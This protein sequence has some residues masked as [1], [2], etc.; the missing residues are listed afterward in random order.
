M[1]GWVKESAYL[2]LLEETG[3]RLD[4]V[5]AQYKVRDVVLQRNGVSMMLPIVDVRHHIDGGVTV[6]VCDA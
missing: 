1:D 2:A 3:K 6:I 4:Y 5:R